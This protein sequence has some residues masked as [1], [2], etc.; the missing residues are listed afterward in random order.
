M[1]TD[2]NDRREIVAQYP[3]QRRFVGAFVALAFVLG[4]VVALTVVLAGRDA[5]RDWTS[6]TIKKEDD[7]VKRAELVASLVERR[8]ADAG[9]G[10]APFFKVT[11]G[12]DLITDL[13]GR[14][15]FVAMASG[16]A[17]P[18]WSFEQ[19]A[20]VFFKLCGGGDGCAFA[21]P[22]GDARTQAFAIATREAKEL[23]LRGLK[24]VPEAKSAIVVLPAGV[25]EATPPPTVVYYWRRSDLEKELDDPLAEEFEQAVPA[26]ATLT[27]QQ[28][29][30]VIGADV[31][32]LFTMTPKAAPDNGALIYELTPPP[33]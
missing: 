25:L 32:H 10:A 26:P 7:P 19:G 15:Q 33:R 14:E 4:A 2:L 31:D 16:P 17:G 1:A 30:D 12:E 23:A 18:P 28:A 21:E 20:L 27:A 24:N 8:Y 9:A 6:H 3:H 11:A 29:Q 5:P 22:A 13:P